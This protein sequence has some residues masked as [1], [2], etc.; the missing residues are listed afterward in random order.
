M[1]ELL[2]KNNETTFHDTEKPLTRTDTTE[3]EIPTS[4]R[5]VRIP[6]LRIAPGPRKIIE[7]EIL[8]ME[9]EETIQKRTG[10]WCP[11]IL[12]RQKDGTTHFCV[13]Y[14]KLND[15]THKDATHC[16]QLMTY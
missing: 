14:H 5:P 2:I 4:G 6:P 3:H 9:K 13:D 1:K 12:V 15:A 10:P 7:D 16:L 8:K 11:I